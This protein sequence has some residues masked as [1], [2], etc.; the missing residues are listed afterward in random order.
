ML[1]DNP[2][3]PKNPLK[4]AMRRRNVKTVQFT[5]P[6]YFEAS[7]VDYSTEEEDD[8]GEFAAQDANHASQ[9]QEQDKD[10]A[11]DETIDLSN[12]KYDE[13]KASDIIAVDS[14]DKDVNQNTLNGERASEETSEPSGGLPYPCAL[15]C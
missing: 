2:E 8:D 9:S 3:K 5:A 14:S 11:E 15:L 10:T 1:G 12:N 7:D 4:I 6:T 13:A